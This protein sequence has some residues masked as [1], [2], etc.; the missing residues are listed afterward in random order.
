[1][2]SEIYLLAASIASLGFAA[3]NFLFNNGSILPGWILLG[4]IFLL[5]GVG[6]AV[7]GSNDDDGTGAEI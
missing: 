1:M 4:L 6:T 5:V 7:F 3:A 2:R